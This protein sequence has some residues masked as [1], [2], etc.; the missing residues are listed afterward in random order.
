MTGGFN[1]S[2][3]QRNKYTAGAGFNYGQSDELQTSVNMSMHQ[4]EVIS[5]QNQVNNGVITSFMEHQQNRM[6]SV[7]ENED[8]LKHV[9]SLDYVD[10][11]IS[12][13]V[14]SQR[15]RGYEQHSNDLVDIQRAFK[16]RVLTFKQL[17]SQQQNR[18][19]DGLMSINREQS[20]DSA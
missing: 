19:E 4:Q 12:N 13:D 1:Q 14:T 10:S 17:K 20:E 9:G 16:N 6:V 18:R 15:G 11:K 5:S 8:I 7:Q 3:K 2:F